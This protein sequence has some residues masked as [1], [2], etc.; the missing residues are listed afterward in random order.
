MARHPD[1]MREPVV[2]EIEDDFTRL[3][4]DERVRRADAWLR[5]IDDDGPVDTEPS[6]VDLLAEARGEAGW[7]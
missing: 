1:E 4:T 3:P 6:M 5:S 7:S 2:V